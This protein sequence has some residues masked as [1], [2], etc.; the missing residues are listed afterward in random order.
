MITAERI[1]SSIKITL[2]LLAICY[3]LFVA[4]PLAQAA[5]LTFVSDTI[6]TSA[7]AANANHTIEFTVTN[8]IPV[9]GQIIITP[10]AGAFTIPA[11]LDFT[12]I[13]LLDDGTNQVLTA[14]PG[15]G[16]GSA[17]GVSVII[18]TSGSLTFTLNDTDVISAGSVITIRIGTNATFGQ[19]GVE[20]IQNPSTVGSYKISIQ[21]KDS[22]GMILDRADAMVAILLPV[23][24]GLYK[25]LV[26]IDEVFSPTVATTATLINPDGTQLIVELPQG[27]VDFS[28][29]IRF[30]ITSFQKEDFTPTASPPSGKSAIG[31]VYEVNAFRVLD[32]S[33]I[34]SLSKSL[35][36]DF[37]YS[38]ADI[39]GIDES[40]LQPYRWD[41]LQWIL[42]P[43]STVFPA[44]NRVSVAVGNF[45]T[46]SLM[47]EPI[48]TPAGGG[49][50]LILQPA[51]KK[52]PV[53]EGPTIE[54]PREEIILP[55]PKEP[56]VEVGPP[57][58]VEEEP[59]PALFDIEVEPITEEPVKQE[60]V[61]TILVIAGVIIIAL[62][63]IFIRKKYHNG[64]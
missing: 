4:I 44:E 56:A 57:K 61:L 19:A 13:D 42:V 43:G 45:S 64:K 3:W 52:L 35:T 63:I 6:S 16:A 33:A 41:G 7:L 14:F 5:S 50:G 11:G 53:T 27:F 17:F 34:T 46:F 26:T 15:S 28:D 55:L 20:Q 12:D 2:L 48:P 58:G 36:F 47:G 60:R 51:I 59:V 39:S 1:V 37:F 8:A 29:D 31:A 9:S 22:D 30:Q 40:T 18:G 23:R 24:L 38:D 10:E 49:G 21:T 54:E 62:S 32:G 25:A